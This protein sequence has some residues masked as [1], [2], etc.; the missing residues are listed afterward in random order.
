M[1]NFGTGLL[2]EITGTKVNYSGKVSG[3]EDI[4]VFSHVVRCKGEIWLSNADSCP[5]GVHSVGRQLVMTPGKPWMG[6]VHEVYP[7]GDPNSVKSREEDREMWSMFDLTND[8]IEELRASNRWSD[9]FG[10]RGSELVFIGIKLDKK[11]M[12]K[13]LQNALLTDAELNVPEDARKKAWASDMTDH[14][15]GGMPLWELEDI[16]E[17]EDSEDVC[18][19]GERG[20]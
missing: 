19:A 5:I 1:K 8:V 12:F 18:D 16:L 7:L 6:K 15:F 11:V 17:E 4:D 20:E 2:A 10:D 3:Q 9:R 14:F 13:E